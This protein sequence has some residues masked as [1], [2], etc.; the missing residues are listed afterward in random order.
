[1]ERPPPLKSALPDERQALLLRACLA[2]HPA[3]AAELGRQWLRDFDVATIDP[4]G[5]RLLGLLYWQLARARVE[6]PEMPRLKGFLRHSWAGNQTHLHRLWPI[7]A[8]LAAAAIPVLV[9]KGLPLAFSIYPDP[10]TRPMEDIDLLV[11]SAQAA[12]AMDCL[13]ALGC[14]RASPRPRIVRDWGEGGA[15][16]FN[17]AAHFQAPS[18]LNLDLHWHSL[19][20]CCHHSAD[21]AFWAR[22]IPLPLPGGELQTLCAEDQLFHTCI[23]GLRANAVSSIRWIADATWILRRAGA[24]LCWPLLIEEARARQLS[25][26]LAEALGVLLAVAA[27]PVPREVL[28]TLRAQV[29]SPMERWEL[30][31]N[32]ATARWRKGAA[33]GMRFLRATPREHG[34]RRWRKFPEFLRLRWAADSFPA[35]LRHVLRRS[36]ARR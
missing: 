24:A 9:L 19:D 30:G 35:M 22:R 4:A 8:A 12:A 15:L 5:Q 29:A 10:G 36:F 11:P 2:E 21:D 7:T 32:L 17:Y 1:M 34:W 13:E 6:H 16:S 20:E 18:G 28:S 27:A 23:H 26:A 33:L 25:H 31:G 3:R 14:V